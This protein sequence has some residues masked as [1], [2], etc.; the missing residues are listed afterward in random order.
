M[1]G[2]AEN[3]RVPVFQ[4]NPETASIEIGAMRN[5]LFFARCRGAVVFL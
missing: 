2:R 5:T 4:W 3:V 1:S